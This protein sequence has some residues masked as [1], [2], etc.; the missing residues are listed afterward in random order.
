MQSSVTFSYEVMI[1]NASYFMQANNAFGMAVH[2]ECKQ[3][4]MELKT[5]MNLPLYNI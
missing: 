2:D 1:I 4:F 3:K 5:K